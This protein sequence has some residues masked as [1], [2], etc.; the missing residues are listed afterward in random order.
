MV[1]EADRQ[2][3]SEFGKH[4]GILID[5]MTIQ[6]DLQISKEGDTW[7]LVGAVD[8]G[9][10]NNRI[11]VIMNG[12]KKIKLATHVFQLIFH[13]FTGFRWPIAYFASETATAHQ[14]FQI[15]WEGV[16]KL[17]DRGFIVDYIMMDG[18]STNRSFSSMLFTV[19]PREEGYMTKNMYDASHKIC[20]IQD[21]MHVLKKIRNNLESSK[22][23][24]EH[25]SGRL[26]SMVDGSVITWDHFIEAFKFNLQ[27]GFRLHRKLSKEH[28]ELTSLTKMRNSL[29]IDVLGKEMLFLMRSYQ[30]SLTNQDSVRGTVRLLQQTCKITEIFCDK[31]RSIT[32]ISDPRLDMLHEV[33]SFF[34][35]WEK[36]VSESTILVSQ[37]HLMSKETRDDLNSSLM[38]FISLCRQHV[39][40]GRAISPGFFNSD[41]IENFFCQQRGIKNGLNTNPTI[42]Q[43]GPSVNSIC[44]GQRTVSSKSNSI[45]KASYF[46]ATVPGALNK[47]SQSHK[48]AKLRV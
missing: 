24:N 6:D 14:I 7:N 13:G 23:V 42:Q 34:N 5:E 32:D 11:D 46:S 19:D 40:N 25:G 21:V 20:I 41:L 1:R 35:T 16:D 27:G 22:S 45:L 26:L 29:A 33:L 48:G 18:A 44:L 12:Q 47:K 2:K 39:G 15:V 10:I 17:D 37:K 30:A 9:E 3:I 38:G 43:Y 8:M 28:L 36:T 4:G 31:N